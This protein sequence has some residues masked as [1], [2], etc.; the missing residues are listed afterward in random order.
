M[1]GGLVARVFLLLLLILF[2]DQVL[3]KQ[4]IKSPNEIAEAYFK[5]VSKMTG[6]KQSMG[7]ME[8]LSPTERGNYLASQCLLNQKDFETGVDELGGE[9]GKAKGYLSLQGEEKAGALFLMR[10]AA[11]STVKK[12]GGVGLVGDG[13]V[14]GVHDV[15]SGGGGGQEDQHSVLLCAPPHSAA[16][17]VFDQ[18]NLQMG[19]PCK[20]G[21][22]G[23]V[24]DC[25]PVNDED[26]QAINNNTIKI[27]LTRHPFDRLIIEYRRSKGNAKKGKRTKRSRRALSRRRRS[28]ARHRNVWKGPRGGGARGQLFRQ[29]IK[30]KVLDV[31]QS[32]VRPV[33]EICGACSRKWN[34]VIRLDDFDSSQV[35]GKVKTGGKETQRKFFSEVTA[36]EMEQLYEKFK[37]D[38]LLFS[39]SLDFYRS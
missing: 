8:R 21:H 3:R 32:V 7:S 22:G 6:R 14:R 1:G 16:K 9:K 35:T 18:I 19:S 26:Q 5:K 29:F 10:A 28:F 12:E 31:E 13:R 11:G 17:A 27:L 20:R 34:Q 30:S 25:D 37:K 36:E 23:K 39:Y 15:H 2:V 38:F 4:V 24:E 33:S